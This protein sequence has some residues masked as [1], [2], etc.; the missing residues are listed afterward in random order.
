[1]TYCCSFCDKKFHYKHFFDNH[2]I[3]CEFFSQTR[4]LHYND[5]DEIMPSNKDMFKLLQHLSLKCHILTNDIEKLKECAFQSNKKTAESILNNVTPLI[6]FDSWIKTFKVDNDCILET[7]NNDSTDGIIKCVRDSIQCK[8]SNF[9]IP[10]LSIK[11]ILYAYVL[12]ENT[13]V[14][15]WDIC[16]TKIIDYFIEFIK[17]EIVKFFCH[18]KDKQ[19][20]MDCDTEMMYL[21]KVTG[22]RINRNKQ[23]ITIKNWLVSICN[24]QTLLIT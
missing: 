7:L 2:R 14:C 8:D 19:P 24:H 21:T 5:E 12:D 4:K 20:S 3:A 15:K 6:S 16:T 11:G 13:N 18:W 17:H 1:M 9:I 23:N 10:I 22:S